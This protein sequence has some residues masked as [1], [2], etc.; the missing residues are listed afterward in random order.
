MPVPGLRGCVD[1][2]SPSSGQATC[3]PPASCNDPSSGETAVNSASAAPT[4]GKTCRRRARIIVLASDVAAH[5]LFNVVPC[6]LVD[7][8]IGRNMQL[9]RFVR[10][11]AFCDHF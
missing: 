10:L 6:W 11:F 3:E 5:A 1:R 7:A 4:P 2:S 9:K 8:L